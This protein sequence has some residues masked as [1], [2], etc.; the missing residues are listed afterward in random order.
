[1]IR[2]PPRSTRTDTLFPYTTLFR[3]DAA[4]DSPRLTT[5]CC[6]LRRLLR[7]SSAPVQRRAPDQAPSCL[8]GPSTGPYT[9]AKTKESVMNKLM[10]SA[11]FALATCS[12]PASTESENLEIPAERNS[13]AGFSLTNWITLTDSPGTPCSQLTAT[14]RNRPT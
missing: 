1:M 4:A 13:V 8:R 5:S 3:S 11:V 10:Y 7:Q 9:L 12:S 6:Q 14:T 2:R